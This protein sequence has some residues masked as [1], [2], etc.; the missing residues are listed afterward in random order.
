MQADSKMC[1]S[2]LTITTIAILGSETSI[3]DLSRQDLSFAFRAMSSLA[4]GLLKDFSV[5]NGQEWWMRTHRVHIP[6]PHPDRT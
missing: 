4:H 2:H 3:L 5:R 1:V 6:W